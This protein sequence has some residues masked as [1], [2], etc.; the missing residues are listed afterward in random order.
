M[1]G[2]ED[3]A[4]KNKKQLFQA[5]DLFIADDDQSMLT[6]SIDESGSSLDS[7][8]T[9]SSRGRGNQGFA[10]M[11]KDKQREI[12]SKGGKAAHQQGTAHEW[13]SSEAAAAGRRGGQSKSS[14][15]SEE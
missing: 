10:S 12:A 5:D 15:T 13:T 2:G 14:A 6:G 1:K 3:M 4:D 8:N 7:T 11:S 9:V